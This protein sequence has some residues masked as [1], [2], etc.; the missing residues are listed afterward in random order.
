M[1]YSKYIVYVG[2]IYVK[3]MKMKLRLTGVGNWPLIWKFRAEVE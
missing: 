1:D 3:S 2:G